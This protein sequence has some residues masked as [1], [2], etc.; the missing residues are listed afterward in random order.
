MKPEFHALY[1]KVPDF[2]NMLIDLNEFIRPRLAIIDG[3]DA[4]EG[5]G[6]S[7]GTVRHADV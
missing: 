7:A 1:P 4:M 6:P 5:N 2:C 3:I